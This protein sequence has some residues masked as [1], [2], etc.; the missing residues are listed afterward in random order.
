MVTRRR[1]LSI[2]AG[3]A[4]TPASASAVATW[5]GRA[6]GADASIMLAQP[7]RGSTYALFRQVERIIAQVEQTFSLHI[8]SELTRLNAAGLLRNPSRAMVEM[9]TLSARMHQATGGVFDPS[10]Q[11]LW[12]AL[13]RGGDA[14]AARHCV[15]WD[16]VLVTADGVQ[17]LAGC[18]LTFNGIAQGSCADQVA[19]FLRSKGYDRVL[20]DTG[21][22]HAL[23][24]GAGSRGWPV[25]IAGPDDATLLQIELAD[26]ALATSSPLALRLA[27]G[28]P[29]I[30]GPRGQLPCWTTVS[31]SAQSAAVADALSTAC[32]MMNRPAIAHTLRHFPDAR[33][34]AI[35]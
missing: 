3:F 11:Q 1:A 2:L 10:I 15:G 16:N 24:R 35:I 6:M 20:V 7:K 30:L 34:E 32:C 9:I 28:E 4:A 26:R 33:I 13:A 23:G 21:E 19:A 31:V 12:L 14:E 18:Q 22:L 8:E 27:R 29:H 25:T 5:Q 17:L